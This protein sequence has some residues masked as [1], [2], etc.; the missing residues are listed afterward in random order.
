M[1][2]QFKTVSSGVAKQIKIHKMGL[3]ICISLVVT[4]MAGI[5]VVTYANQT[6]VS[7]IKL[8][9]SVEAH[10]SQTLT[11]VTPQTIEVESAKVVQAEKESSQFEIDG[12]GPKKSLPKSKEREIEKI[13]QEM[14]ATSPWSKLPGMVVGRVVNMDDDSYEEQIVLET[15]TI[16]LDSDSTEGGDVPGADS[17]N[18]LESQDSNV[19]DTVDNQEAGSTPVQN[20]AT[21]SSTIELSED[22]IEEGSTSTPPELIDEGSG[23]DLSVITP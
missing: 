14:L 13:R 10:N 7:K 4:G 21:A 3:F 9:P 15:P 12:P 8:T 20:V 18:L 17:I 22:E 23:E 6:L 16:P 2:N 19:I 11:E 5:A 1:V